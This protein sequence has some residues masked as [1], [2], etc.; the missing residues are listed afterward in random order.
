MGQNATKLGSKQ[1]KARDAILAGRTTT[2]AAS[3]AGVHRS[4]VH[5]WLDDAAFLASLNARRSELRSAADSRLDYRHAE[6][7]DLTMHGEAW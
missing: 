3:E 5:G 4:T 7:L 6:A 1:L 2:Q